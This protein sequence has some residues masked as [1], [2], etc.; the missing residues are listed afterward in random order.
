MLRG[1]LA[2]AVTPLREGGDALDEA[3]FGPMLA[4]LSAGGVDGVL[5]LGTTGEGI[6]LS[7][8]ERRRAAECFLVARPGEDFAVAVHCG[9]QTTRDTEALS[10]H[11]AAGGADAVAVIAPPYFA[12]D[13]GALF[14]HF[15]AAAAACAPVP[16]YVY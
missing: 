5:A 14:A 10:A 7:V 4:F 13:T 9:A 16:F 2:A 11:A 1:A 3:A 12:L 8:E 6:L 15:R